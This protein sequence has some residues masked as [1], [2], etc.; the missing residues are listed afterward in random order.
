MKKT[1][2]RNRIAHRIEEE[3]KKHGPITFEKFTGHALYDE[4]DGYYRCGK[5]EIGKK[6]DFYTNPAAH[7]AFGETLARVISDL[8]NKIA[9]GADEKIT[10]LEVGGA[11]SVLASDI[12]DSLARTDPETY[13][14]VQ[15]S[16]LDLC[17]PR[18]CAASG[19]HPNFR[20]IKSLADAGHTTGIILSNELFDAIPFHRLVFRGGKI[21][22]IFVSLGEDGFTET[23]SVPSSADLL[24]YFDRFGGAEEMGFLEGQQF[25]IRPAAA[26][27]LKQMAD[28]LVKGVILTID[29][30]FR[31]RELFSPDRVGGTFKCVS[32]HKINESPYENI[33]NQDITAHV[34]FENLEK[35]G[36]VSGLAT[37]KYTTQGQFL[38]DW[39]IIDVAG[40]NPDEILA[41]KNL[42]MPTMMGD[43]FRVLMQSKNAPELA[44]GFY[45]ES[46]LRIS[47]GVD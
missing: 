6:G 47:F 41:I 9:P 42:F 19:V 30:G 25:E 23:E 46:P 37:L 27:M 3:I 40:Q 31:A 34:D 14:A 12:L 21:R 11:N 15:Y 33:G 22:E 35:A 2:S 17:E 5:A 29:Y 36:E 39:G 8:R 32:E 20:R 38:V 26:K 10:V 4:D 43:S 18:K 13:G 24:K 7:R 45:P 16:L 28:T 1:S 44:Q